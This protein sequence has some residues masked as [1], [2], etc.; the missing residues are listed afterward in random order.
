[1]EKKSV[2]KKSIYLLGF[3]IQ[4]LNQHKLPKKREV[5]SLFIHKHISHKWTIY[6]SAKYVINR[7]IEIWSKFGIPVCRPH[8]LIE[9]L[10][11]L[12]KE[13][14]AVKKSKRK[15]KFAMKKKNEANFEDKMNEL[16]DIASPNA[17]QYLTNEQKQILVKS[18][19]GQP[20]Y[21]QSEN[22]NTP[23]TSASFSPAE[24]DDNG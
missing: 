3:E 2:R 21:G 6:E 18:R 15:K 10:Q 12:Y 13:Y 1:M 7:I 4:K 23:G 9:K 22:S 8:G 11:R 24:M 16:F 14:T 17:S 19:N 5:L 20:A